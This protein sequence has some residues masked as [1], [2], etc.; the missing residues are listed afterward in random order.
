[1]FY[2]SVHQ[3]NI[4][5]VY[6]FWLFVNSAPMNQTALF[7]L[8]SHHACGFGQCFLRSGS[9]ASLMKIRGLDSKPNVTRKSSPSL[10]RSYV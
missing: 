1:M 4:W 2:L 5:V 9:E 10:A 7:P 8:S 6:V 3:L